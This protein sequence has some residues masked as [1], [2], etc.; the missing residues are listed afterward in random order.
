[1]QHIADRVFFNHCFSL[2]APLLPHKS[3]RI[4]TKR[5]RS[6]L[7]NVV[8]LGE[9][10]LGSLRVGGECEVDEF[11]RLFVISASHH[12]HPRADSWRIL[13]RSLRLSLLR[14]RAKGRKCGGTEDEVSVMKCSDPVAPMD[15]RAVDIMIYI[16]GGISVALGLATCL[17][18]LFFA[19]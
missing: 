11:G 3:S 7:L 17:G 19:F 14:I 15:D 9:L 2:N 8:R 18:V 13:S 4:A 12:W 10:P 1:M 5:L 16:L 6:V